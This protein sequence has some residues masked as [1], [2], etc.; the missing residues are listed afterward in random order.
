MRIY[1]ILDKKKKGGVLT[2]EEIEFFVR[3]ITDGTVADYQISAFTMAVCIRGM[4]EDE[5]FYL[6]EAM[7]HS[8]DVL[9]LS[10]F[11]EDS[12]DKHSTGGVGDKTSMICLPIAASL[13]CKV[14]KMSG[15]GLGHTG[16]TVDK[17][18]TIRGYCVDISEEKFISQTTELGLCMIGQT[19]DLAPADKK[20][21]A[22]RDVTAT[23]DS[24]PLIAS[25]IMSKKLA[26]GAKNIVLD[27]KYGS[28]AF[29]P[30]YESAKRLAD[31]MIKIGRRFGRRITAVL[32]DMNKPLGY[33]VGNLME[34]G[35]AVAV[36]RG[37]FRGSDIHEVSIEL[38]ANLVSM[39]RGCSYEEAV[40]LCEATV[41]PDGAAITR[42]REWMLSQ[43]A[44]A[45]FLDE[46]LTSPF[47][48]DFFHGEHTVDFIAPAG[49]SSYSC[50]AAGVGEAAMLLGAGRART[51]DIIDGKAGIQFFRKPGDEIKE[52]DVIATLF[53]SDASKLEAGL[54]RLT[55]AVTFA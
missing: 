37:D 27:V 54:A 1:D 4:N 3:G 14:A 38:A 8:G 2:K 47:Q 45:D 12:A 34:V 26:A 42:M 18:E 6:T 51:D 39:V 53:A 25:S 35:E 49:V 16:G 9:D 41:G 28:G 13:G 31:E 36:L 46:M 50:N 29:M 15:R 20:I 24:M 44:D 30:D 19:A 7:M 17:L 22:I 11:G 52:G 33:C 40:A 32:S 21:Y 48:S 23:V 43:G 10:C 55:G 5:T